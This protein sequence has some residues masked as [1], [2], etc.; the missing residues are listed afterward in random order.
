MGVV[1]PRS[2]HARLVINGEDQGLFSLVES[3]DGTFTDDHFVGGDGNLYKEIWHDIDD[4]ELLTEYLKTNEETADHTVFL[5][6]HADLA[7]AAE[8]ALPAALERYLDLDPL[9][10]YLAVERAIVDW[11]GVG[12]FYCFDDYCENH[13]YYLY[14][15][16]NE[17]RFTLIPWDLDNTFTLDSPLDG[18]PGFLEIPSDCEQRYEAVGRLV[19]PPGC[20]RFFRALALADRARYVAQLDRLLAGPFQVATLRG[21]LERWQAQIDPVVALDAAGPGLGAFRQ[22]AEQLSSILPD[23]RAELVAH[24]D[25]QP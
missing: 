7:A 23:L 15:H 21:W 13:N 2:A 4:P 18:V 14:Q 22:A 17:P 20:D 12:A 16:E 1:A 9:F 19:Q 8:P 25:A 6:M 11:D 3:I 10:A 24:R 5:Q